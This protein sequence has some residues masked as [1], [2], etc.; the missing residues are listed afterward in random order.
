VVFECSGCG[1]HI[2]EDNLLDAGL[3]VEGVVLP[4]QHYVF[5]SKCNTAEDRRRAEHE[6]ASAL[7]QFADRSRDRLPGVTLMRAPTRLRL[8]GTG[9]QVKSDRFAQAT[10]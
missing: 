7:K 4:G 3:T 1:L 2:N 10:V 9:E 5:L 8:P 6:A